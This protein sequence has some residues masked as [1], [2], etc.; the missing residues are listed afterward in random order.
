[1]RLER[2]KVIG[3]LY[4]YKK[5]DDSCIPTRFGVCITPNELDQLLEDMMKL[6]EYA[7]EKDKRILYSLIQEKR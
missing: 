3:L 2:N 5:E 6:D 1:M 7:I 4:H